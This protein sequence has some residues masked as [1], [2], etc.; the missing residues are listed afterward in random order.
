MSDEAKGD[1]YYG[2]HFYPGICQY[3]E[4]NEEP[5]RVFLNED[6][7]RSMDPSFAGRPVFVL[8]VDQI[9][10]DIN[11]LRKEADGWVSESFY[12]QADG[13]HWVKFVVVSSKGKEAV[14]KGLKL[15]N[16]YLPKTLG[17]GGT[18]NGIDYK[19][20]ITEAVY[21]HLAI[22]P[23][24]RYEESII[25]TPE[26]FK[27]YNDSKIEELKKLKNSKDE[28]KSMFNFFK[29]T[30]VEN[31]VD[32]ES[33][34]VL[35]PKSKQE[36]MI[37]KLIN[38][39]DEHEMEKDQQK[40]CDDADF[41]EHKGEKMSLGDFKAKHDKMC[42]EIKEMKSQHYDDLKD[43]DHKEEESEVDGKENRYKRLKKPKNKEGEEDYKGYMDDDDAKEPIDPAAMNDEDEDLEYS[44]DKE[45]MSPDDDEDM[46]K[47][48]HLRKEE[49]RE[50]KDSKKK[51]NS[52]EIAKEKA[53]RLRNAHHDFSKYDEGYDNKEVQLGVHQ[54]QRG[55]QLFGS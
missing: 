32:L 48:E 23:N 33:M 34:S 29:R 31:S 27:K 16:C 15:S 49:D 44:K 54:V 12:N 52:K 41:V 19:N 6:T 14:S 9:E 17:P 20:E 46:A 18:W 39:A 5:Y 26:D 8:H 36:I 28:R 30:K 43:K 40:F 53:D 21:E 45:P 35:L 7:L 42:D 51:K 24:P 38:D 37:S 1:I 25:L 47:E 3:Q 10:T 22:V 55:K 2:I 11:Q 13:K 4:G 50:V